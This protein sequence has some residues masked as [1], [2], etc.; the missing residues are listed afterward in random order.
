MRKLT[1]L[2]MLAFVFSFI[3]NAFA[4]EIKRDAKIAEIKGSAQVK[5][6]GGNWVPAQVGMV[7]AQGYILKTA[8]N[9]KAVLKLNG[10]GETA[11]VVVNPDSQLLLSEL[12]AD[13][14]K[15][16][17]KTLLDLA[18]GKILIKAQKLHG[19]D[20]KFEVKTPTSVVGVRGTSFSVEVSA[21]E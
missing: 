13:K 10:S 2:V 5:A 9:S 6:V 7:L 17:E 14:A 18:V 3:N 21:V 1:L 11:T 15:G 4:D 8:A 19:P 12:L 20:S 16:T